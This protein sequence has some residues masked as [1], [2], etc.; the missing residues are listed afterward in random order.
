MSD[1]TAR[2][3]YG[4]SNIEFVIK[5]D[6]KDSLSG[7]TLVT[8][9]YGIGKVGFIS[10][11]HMVEKLGAI[12][13]GAVLTDFLPP[14]LSVKE[15]RLVLPFEIYKHEDIIFLSAFF[16]PYK[17]EHRSFAHA[18]I[19][20]AKRNQ[21]SHA[22][23]IGGLDSRLKADDE[24][25]AKGVY[26]SVFMK[27]F[28]QTPVPMM[29]EGLF[30]TGPM[31]L[32]LMY[33]ELQDFPAMGIMPYAERSRPDPIAASHAVELVNDLLQTDIGVDELVREA[34]SIETELQAMEGML[35]EE[36]QDEN[37]NRDAGMF[38]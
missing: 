22:I 37:T 34:E 17:Y 2:S 28:N 30:I 20:W 26:S 23:L 24:V 18:L 31:A 14:F 4:S 21:M 25:I 6:Y 35:E 36:T 32:V 38:M 16:E 27:K 29:D 5:D 1:S 8:G 19:Q 3:G 10:V 7:C 33:A 12:R 15:N 11:N 13:I 9:F